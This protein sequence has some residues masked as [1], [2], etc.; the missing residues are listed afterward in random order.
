MPSLLAQE[1]LVSKVPSGQK[2]SAGAFQSQDFLGLVL[3]FQVIA[4]RSSWE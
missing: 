4:S 3:S 2:S 1:V